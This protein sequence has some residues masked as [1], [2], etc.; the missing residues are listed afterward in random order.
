M[1]HPIENTLALLQDAMTAHRQALARGPSPEAAAPL[2]PPHDLRAQL[3]LRL[4]VG[5]EMRAGIEVS[6]P[7]AE[8]LLR[9][10]ASIEIAEL[11]AWVGKL[12]ALPASHPEW[13]SL[14]E[15]LTVHETY[16]MRDPPQF[17]FFAAQ[18]PALIAEAAASKSYFLRF[19]SVGCATGE[20][21]YSIA[22]LALDAMVATGHAIATE[23]GASLLPPWRI[24][25]IG[26]DISRLVLTQARAGVYDTGPLSSFRDESAPLLRH[27]PAAPLVGSN[28]P[29]ARSASADL[30]AC[31]SFEHFNIIDDPMPAA[32]FDAVFCRNVLIYF[33][34]RARLQA[35][36]TLRRAVRNGGYLL[37]GPTDTLIDAETFEALWA[38]GAVIY[39]RR[40]DDA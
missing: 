27:F 28:G 34:A 38:P 25:V 5:V 19:W 30:K 13:L 10:L 31:V 26:S 22:A 11:E 20:E 36:E 7:A 12:D 4:L 24:E 37:L 33:S 40:K 9:I 8:K 3:V 39:R 17:E 23:T 2:A 16:V 14:I 6:Q 1:A 29:L 18:L 15:S 21:A 35:Q 32:P